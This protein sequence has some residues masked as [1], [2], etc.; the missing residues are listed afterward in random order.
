MPGAKRGNICHV[1]IDTRYTAASMPSPSFPSPGRGDRPQFQ[2][3]AIW[4]L[5]ER[6]WRDI[7]LIYV[8]PRR[9][10]QAER[11]LLCDSARAADWRRAG[12]GTIDAMI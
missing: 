10:F 2:T 11:L 6:R 8:S 4:W 12:G 7:A 9:S 5:A 3:A 1:T